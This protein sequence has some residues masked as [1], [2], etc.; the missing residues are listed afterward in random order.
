MRKITRAAQMPIDKP[1][2]L[3]MENALCRQKFREAMVK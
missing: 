2:T 1:R 3:M